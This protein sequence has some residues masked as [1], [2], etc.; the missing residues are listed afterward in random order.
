MI[1]IGILLWVLAAL[2]LPSLIGMLILYLRAFLQELRY[3]NTEIARAVGNERHF[4]QRKRRRL[5][6][7]LLPF[8]R[9]RRKR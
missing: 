4:W 7:S 8:V 6:L 3:L 2:I 9:Y 5:W 1:S